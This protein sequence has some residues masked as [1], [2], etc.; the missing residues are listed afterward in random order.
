MPIATLRRKLSPI[1]EA[2]VASDTDSR[3]ILERAEN[4]V[5]WGSFPILLV[6]F[7][8]IFGGAISAGSRPFVPAAIFVLVFG[9]S[10]GVQ[11]RRAVRRE[12]VEREIMLRSTAISYPILT[13]VM[14]ASI[15]AALL[16][17]VEPDAALVIPMAAAIFVQAAVEGFLTW[18]MG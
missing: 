4:V 12:G 9:L 5:L 16:D 14:I 11:F 2:R 6:C 13:T 10:A 3:G 1:S 17:L 8:W 18:H 7:L 15:M